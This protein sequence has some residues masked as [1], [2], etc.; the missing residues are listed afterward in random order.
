MYKLYLELRSIA[1][2]TMVVAMRSVRGCR[3]GTQAMK[4]AQKAINVAVELAKEMGV[5]FSVEK[6]VVMCSLLTKDLVPTRCQKA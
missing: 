3:C 2:Y 4:D 5:E 6:T 1:K